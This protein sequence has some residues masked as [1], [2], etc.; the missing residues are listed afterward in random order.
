MKP[1]AGRT[2]FIPAPAAVSAG[3]SPW[4][5]RGTVRTWSLQ[6][7]SGKP[8]PKLPGTVYSVASEVEAAGGEALPLIM[9]VREEGQVR[10]AMAQ[11]GATS[12]ASTA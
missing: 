2:L 8:H 10:E 12:A 1:L 7:K 3:P 9:D 5:P 11:A 6:P 4:P